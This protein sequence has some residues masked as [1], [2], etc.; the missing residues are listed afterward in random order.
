SRRILVPF[1]AKQVDTTGLAGFWVVNVLSLVGVTFLAMYI[2]W[3]LRGVAGAHAPLAYRIIPL[4]LVGAVFLSARNN[5]HLI[6]TYPALT[7]PLALLLLVSAVGLVVA[8]ELP[9]TRLLLIPVCFLAP[10][11]LEEL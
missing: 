9:S 6:A 8:A 10:L 7:D 1:L 2:A 5:F 4:L 11:A 3:R